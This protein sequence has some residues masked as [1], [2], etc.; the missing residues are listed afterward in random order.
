MLASTDGLKIV[1]NYAS[2]WAGV[3]K[4]GK[5]IHQDHVERVYEWLIETHFEVE[6]TARTGR[7]PEKI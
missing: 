6:Q 1:A 7:M 2:D 3:Y 4:N 5:L